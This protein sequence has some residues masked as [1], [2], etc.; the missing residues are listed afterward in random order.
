M[1]GASGY[2]GTVA[3]G[4]RAHRLDETSALQLVHTMVS[5]PCFG[6]LPKTSSSWPVAAWL[7]LRARRAE[8][9]KSSTSRTAEDAAAALV[10]SG[11]Q[12]SSS[13]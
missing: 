4:M 6:R 10:C 13:S 12:P 5:E 11:V 3:F 7:G 9:S 1:A 8:A 2:L